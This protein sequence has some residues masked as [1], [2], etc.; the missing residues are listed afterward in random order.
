ML[1]AKNIHKYYGGQHVLKGIDLYIKKG[2]FLCIMGR[3]GSG[4]TTLLNILAGMDSPDVGS[5]TIENKKLNFANDLEMTKYR[6][7]KLGF[8]FQFFNLLDNLSLFENVRIP[9][10]LNKN[11]NKNYVFEVLE[12]VGLKG[13][14]NKLPAQLS[15]GEKQRA[16]IA[17]AIIHKPHIIFADEPTG[18]LDS[19]TSNQILSLLKGLHS[20]SKVTI[21]LVTHDDEVASWSKRILYL[22]DGVLE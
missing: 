7:K 9:L 11:Y 22:S 4:K 1:S 17:R 12:R 10:L 16:A 2:E 6:R 14:E 15:G 8:I 13:L 3:S 19:E 20:E 18:S 5:I 21:I